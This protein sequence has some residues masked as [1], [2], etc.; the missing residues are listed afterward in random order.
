LLVDTATSVSIYAPVL[1]TNC[2][3]FALHIVLLCELELEL[4]LEFAF[5]FL[6][7]CCDLYCWLPLYSSLS[8]TKFLL[9][10]QI[11]NHKVVQ[12]IVNSLIVATVHIKMVIKKIKI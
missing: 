2:V 11:E 1:E 5:L 10:L 7:G 9:D 12:H 6:Y 3:I 4:E 8:L